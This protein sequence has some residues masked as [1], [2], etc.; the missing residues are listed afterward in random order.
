MIEEQGVQE[1]AAKAKAAMKAGDHKLCRAY[2]GEI[3][4][5]IVTRTPETVAAI[6][7]ARGLA[8]RVRK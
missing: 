5:L 3:A 7:S 4:A 8:K 6:E 2:M 1:I